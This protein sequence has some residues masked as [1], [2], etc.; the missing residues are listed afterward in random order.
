MP[1]STF[2][3]LPP[4]KRERLLA[5]ARA[6]FARVSLAGASVNR[7]IRQA[8]IPRGS[9]YMYFADKE[10]LFFYLLEEY[11]QQLAET[12]SAILEEQ[13][14]DLFGAFLAMFDRIQ[15]CRDGTWRMLLDI[16]RRNQQMRS[17]IFLQR[18]REGRLLEFPAG[19]V[20]RTRLDLR[21]EGDLE[22]IVYLLV[23]AAMEAV[24]AADQSGDRDGARAQLVQMF[25]II[26]RGAERRDAPETK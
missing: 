24:R 20:D 11:R 14:G 4:E 9:F 16:L 7:I 2:F 17:S 8:G 22:S 23:S 1:T 6:E 12:M 19:R 26:R 13:A 10:E 18:N 5:A 3:N 25:E 15:D 21:Q